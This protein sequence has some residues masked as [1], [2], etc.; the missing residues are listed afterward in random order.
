MCT[1]LTSS[2]VEQVLLICLF[3]WASTN[4]AFAQSPSTDPAQVTVDFVPPRLLGQVTPVYPHGAVVEAEVAVRVTIDVDGRISGAEPDSGPDAF[5]AVS[6]DAARQLQFEP[7]TRGGEPV[8]ATVVVI[9]HFAP[10]SQPHALHEDVAFEVVVEALH[11]DR[12]DTH[13]RTTLDAEALE[14]TRGLDLAESIARVPGV[15]VG[16]GTGDSTKPII[17][18]QAERR[19]LVLFDGVR[20][21]SQKWGADHAT[22]IDPLS[23]GEISVIKGAAG[24]RY[25]PD[26]IGGVVLVEPPPLRLEPG[27]EGTVQLVGQSNGLRGIGALSLDVVPAAVP[28]LAVRVQGNYARGAALT[29]PDYVLGNTGGQQWNLGARARYHLSDAN[30]TLAYQHYDLRAGLCYCVRNGTIDEF[31]GQVDADV[32]VGSDAW[33]VAYTIDRAYQ[34]VTHDVVSARAVFALPGGGDLRAMYAYQINH[35]QEFEQARTSVTGPQYDFTLRTHSLDLEHRHAVVDLGAGCSISGN[36]GLTGTF[37]ENVYSGLPLI[38]NHRIGGGGLFVTERL[39]TPTA[40]LEIGARYDHQSR[41]SFLTHSAFDRHIARDLLQEESC[42]RTAESARCQRRFDTGSVSAGLLW[43]VVPDHVDLKF[44]LSSASRFPN[45]DELY[46]NGSAPTS[47]VYALGDPSLRVETTW[48]TSSTVGLRLPW[49]HAEAS[50][51]ANLID[52]YITFAPELNDQGQPKFDVTVRGAY[53]R[54]VYRQTNALFYGVDG[55]LTLGPRWPVSLTTQAS[56][57]RA[58]DRVAHQPLLFV[59]P[60]RF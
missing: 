3:G 57:V 31:L 41:S 16:R 39:S 55:G 44:D 27:V 29:A 13:A 51:Y 32:P 12:E 49:I 9:F 60:D 15:S 8:P 52:R 7:A 24:V 36:A 23:A 35:R 50:A 38:P 22:E 30:F 33:Q 26:A 37:Q 5:I 19:L 25:G 4:S 40:D 11:P 43:H 6:L 47:P 48:G 20:L 21:E 56:L 42:E 14:Q 58:D 34:A 45:G 2:S 28:D 18:G 54:F 53:P 1:L 17:R 10:P 59:P 46:M